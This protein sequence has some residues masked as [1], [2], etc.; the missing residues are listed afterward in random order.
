MKNL[1]S[2]TLLIFAASLS[3]ISCKK[4]KEEETTSSCIISGITAGYVGAPTDE[5][6]YDSQGRILSYKTRYNS[7]EFEYSGLSGTITTLDTLGNVVDEA[8]LTFDSQGRLTSYENYATISGMSLRY[9]YQMTYNSEGYLATNIQTLKGG[10]SYDD[11]YK[12]SLIYENGNLVKKVV[13]T[14][15][16][17]VYETT[18][19]T[20]G[21]EPN[22]TWNFFFNYH[23]EPFSILSG[24]VFLYPLLGKATNHLPT[25]IS[26]IQGSFE[27]DISFDYLTNEKGYVDEYTK[28]IRNSYENSSNT[29]KLSY[30]C[31]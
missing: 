8:D 28:H 2:F 12:D 9:F 20:Y 7:F 5:F 15:E 16:G 11:Y 26:I 14:R 30:K 13:K 29:S 17:Y 22:K 19:Y 10:S 4:D 24:Y 18:S 3:I 21:S 23:G 1:I 6:I 31:Q 25:A 27:N